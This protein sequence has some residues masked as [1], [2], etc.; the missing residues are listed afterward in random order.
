MQASRDY[1]EAQCEAIGR[2]A[3]PAI[4]MS[5]RVNFTAI[6]GA[7]VEDGEGR[8]LRGHGTPE[9]VAEDM[10]G[11]VEAAGVE[12]FQI[13]FNGTPSLG[14]LYEQMALFMAEVKPRLG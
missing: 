3:R 9:Q 10:A 14:H 2:A 11:Y 8:R 4:R 1:L 6:T 13:N 7:K 5:F 12:A